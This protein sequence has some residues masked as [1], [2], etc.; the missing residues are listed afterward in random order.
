MWEEAGLGKIGVV[1]LYFALQAPPAIF[2]PPERRLAQSIH[3]F[4]DCDRWNRGYVLVEAAEI[5]TWAERDMPLNEHCRTP[6]WP[7]SD[8]VRT[9][10]G[11]IFLAVRRARCTNCRD[12]TLRIAWK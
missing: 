5:L 1:G 9:S 11:L 12:D 2:D 7:N 4:H 10:P 3:S 6:L 8:R